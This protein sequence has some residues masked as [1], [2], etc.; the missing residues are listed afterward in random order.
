MKGD[1][2][3]GGGPGREEEKKW[4]RRRNKLKKHF[5]YPSKTKLH[6]ESKFIS[7]RFQELLKQIL[8]DTHS[9]HT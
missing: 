7:Y 9:P 3:E 6:I 5:K 8:V 1:E 2:E 4:R